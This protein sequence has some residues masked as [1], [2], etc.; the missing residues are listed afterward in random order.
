MLS[1]ALNCEYMEGI[2]LVEKD[3]SSLF[4]ELSV[5]AVNIVTSRRRPF[6]GSLED[7]IYGADKRRTGSDVD[8]PS[9]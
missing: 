2:S 3:Y 8:E 9:A 1:P 7:I 6:G 5:V 4:K